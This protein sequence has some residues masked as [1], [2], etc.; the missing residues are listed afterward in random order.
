MCFF[1]FESPYPYF[2]LNLRHIVMSH[3]HCE[4]HNKL[5]K[6]SGVT[7]ESMGKVISSQCPTPKVEVTSFCLINWFFLDF[8]YLFHYQ[9][10]GTCSLS[11]EFF[12]NLPQR[13]I[14]DF[15][16]HCGHLF[17]YCVGGGGVSLSSF[18][19]FQM[20]WDTEMGWL[21]LQL[22]ESIKQQ[23]YYSGRTLW[24]TVNLFFDC[25]YLQDLAFYNSTLIH[26]FIIFA[27]KK[28]VNVLIAVFW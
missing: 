8:W 7:M 28:I 26:F 4:M 6:T 13:L 2:S 25:A 3:I 27:L 1:T 17:M 19:A 15:L 10:K 20:Q 12:S 24:R 22:V 21:I 5:S 11:E 14:L 18:K 9:R 16:W 23:Q